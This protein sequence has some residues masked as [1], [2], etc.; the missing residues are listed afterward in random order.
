MSVADKLSLE[1]RLAKVLSTSIDDDGEY[2]TDV[3]DSLIDIGDPEDIAE[4]LSSFV[5]GGDDDVGEDCQLYAQDVMKFKRGERISSAVNAKPAAEVMEVTK[6][7]A[8]I[9]DEAA[10]HREEIKRREAEAR[11]KQQEERE[12]LVQQK[13]EEEKQR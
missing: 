10:A 6:P 4:Y 1:Q 5:A 9:W 2:V 11:E 12:R 8:K 13:A 7:K 3:L